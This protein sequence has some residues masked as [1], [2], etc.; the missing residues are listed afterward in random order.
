MF[1][2]I[3]KRFKDM[4]IQ[5][6]NSK[7]NV[8]NIDALV[9][10][11]VST[12]N[13]T[14][15]ELESKLTKDIQLIN[16]DVES[17]S[18]YAEN[19]KVK[20]KNLSQKEENDISGLNKKTELLFKQI[21]STNRLIYSYVQEQLFNIE[22]VR[23]EMKRENLMH[24]IY[25]QI[26]DKQIYYIL[27]IPWYKKITRRQ[28]EKINNNIKKIHDHTFELSKAQI[29]DVELEIK[30]HTRE[31]FFAKLNNITKEI[32]NNQKGEN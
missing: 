27:S 21:D 23:L 6:K 17:L 18:I 8:N 32:K 7:Y 3:K 2:K 4:A 13:D 25:E 28:R 29:E 9:D 31:K 20:L 26:I 11:K 1:E 14:V 5:F 15:S 10:N 19:F 24:Y 12:I 30:N 22:K 16:E